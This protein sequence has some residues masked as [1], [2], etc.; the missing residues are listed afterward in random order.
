MVG[1]WRRPKSLERSLRVDGIVPYVKPKNENG[2]PP[3]PEDIRALRKWL[4]EHGKGETFDVVVEGQ[5]PGDDLDRAKE[6]MKEWEEAGA[7]WWIE[8]WWG[9]EADRVRRLRQG[10]PENR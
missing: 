8:S 10:P 4:V 9:A 1:A 2:Q 6:M 3:T 7:T 5:T